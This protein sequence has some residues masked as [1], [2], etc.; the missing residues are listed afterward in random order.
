MSTHHRSALSQNRQGEKDD[1]EPEKFQTRRNVIVERELPLQI[2]DVA[3]NCL[4]DIFEHLS[5]VDLLN[6][7]DTNK[8]F[9]QLAEMVFIRK[10]NKMRVE[11]RAEKFNVSIANIGIKIIRVGTRPYSGRMV[12]DDLSIVQDLKSS[13][14]LLR[15]F[16][17]HVDS[18]ECSNIAEECQ[19][20][21]G[22]YLSILLSFD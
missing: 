16:G 22:Q 12:A 11:S 5:L 18:L 7:S 8:R 3:D 10:R 14:Q 4:L 21:I 9:K 15:C 6:V 2:S 20:K 1:D 17:H 13:L 19:M